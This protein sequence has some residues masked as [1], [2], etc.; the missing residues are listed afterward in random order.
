MVRRGSTVRVRQRA[1]QK[2][3]KWPF[4]LREGTRTS[5]E[6]PSTC[7]QDLSPA[8][9]CREFLA[10]IDAS[11]TAEHLRGREVPGA[12]SRQVPRNACCTPFR[13]TTSTRATALSILVD[14][15]Y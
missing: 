7:P 13:R 9:T 15:R 6:R 12:G 10:R 5:P 8:S 3:S 4:L 1:S 11:R 2:A 14:E